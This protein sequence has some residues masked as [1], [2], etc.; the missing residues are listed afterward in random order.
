MNMDNKEIIAELERIDGLL[1]SFGNLDR[2]FEQAKEQKEEDLRNIY[3]EYHPKLPKAPSAFDALA[4][5]PGAFISLHAGKVKIFS[6]G[7]VASL[8]IWLI[9]RL[10]PPNGIVGFAFVATLV[11]AVLFFRAMSKFNAE[12]KEYDKKVDQRNKFQEILSSAHTQEKA[13]FE[14][15]LTDYYTQYQIFDHKFD[16]YYDAY[17]VSQQKRLDELKVLNEQ[18]DAV[19]L[20][21]QDYLYLAGSIKELLQYGRADTFKEALNLAIAEQRDMEFKARQLEEESRRTAIAEQQAYEER[22][23]NQKMEAEAAAQSRQAQMQSQIA[24][25]QLKA[26]EQQNKQL[27][28]ILKNQNKR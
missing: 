1:V 24:E 25:A 5:E 28:E 12:K 20:L 16:E 7:F 3:H 13:R 8:V 22:M 18:L 10:L 14:A 23:H 21:S 6:L 9:T 2:A 15:A 4:Q 17:M 19:T 26:T 11:F 27:Q